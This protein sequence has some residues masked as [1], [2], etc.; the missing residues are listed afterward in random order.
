MKNLNLIKARKKKK[1]S[2]EQLAKM[3]GYKGKQSVANWENGHVSPPLETAL[4]ISQIFEEDI[5]FLFGNLVQETHT[6]GIEV[7]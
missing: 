1:L 6:S 2:Q 5:F 4:K 7:V 3:L